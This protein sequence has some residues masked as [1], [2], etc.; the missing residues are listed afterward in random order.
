MH[1]LQMNRM[2]R[3]RTGIVLLSVLTGIVTIGCATAPSVDGKRFAAT[4]LSGDDGVGVIVAR[5]EE[6][7]RSRDKECA[8]VADLS[9]AQAEFERCITGAMRRERRDINIVPGD[10][11]L[12]IL[13]TA[14]QRIDADSEGND[15]PACLN[16]PEMQKDPELQEVLA[17]LNVR[18]L[19]VMFIKT[20]VSKGRAT[21]ALDFIEGA[22]FP[23]IPVWAVG[24]ES[25]RKTGIT[26]RIFDV[27]EA[28]EAGYLTTGLSGASG[29][30]VPVFC[31]V[32][33]P[34]VPYSTRTESRTC[35]AMGK[36]IARFIS[37]AGNE[38]IS[39][40]E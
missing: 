6:C 15:L 5:Y 13:M 24:S 27:Q 25:I 38:Y 32:P 2:K 39:E 23:P 40:R 7:L 14:C 10:L 35:S 34:P 28:A 19:V 26:A 4:S 31:I 12:D 33:L 29:C 22:P 16:K 36:S 1:E 21:F 37:G 20:E 9:K 11:I 18:Y 30:I 17:S 8:P 3:L